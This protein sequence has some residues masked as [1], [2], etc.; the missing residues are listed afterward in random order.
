MNPLK[1]EKWPRGVFCGARGTLTVR[2]KWAEGHHGDVIR[3]TL[4]NMDKPV[5]TC[6]SL[7]DVGTCKG[8][9]SGALH[10]GTCRR[11]WDSEP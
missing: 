3:F 2:G 11:V 5:F 7:K 6:Q 10:S 4:N 1:W 8:G 9:T